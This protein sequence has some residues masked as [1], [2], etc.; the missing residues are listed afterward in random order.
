MEEKNLVH[1]LFTS[2]L[3]KQNKINLALLLPI[4]R[5]IAT[6]SSPSSQNLSR[7]YC[8]GKTLGCLLRPKREQIDFDFVELRYA[9]V[10]NTLKG[11]G[12]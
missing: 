2:N 6:L 9:T 8:C 11:W 7:M 4:G 10:L 3:V 5:E 12:K 1:R